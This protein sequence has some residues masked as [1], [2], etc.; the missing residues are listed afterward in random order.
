MCILLFLIK[1]F[2]LG[3]QNEEEENFMEEVEQIVKD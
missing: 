1:Y 2:I 3:K